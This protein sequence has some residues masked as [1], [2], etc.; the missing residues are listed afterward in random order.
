[1]TFKNYVFLFIDQSKDEPCLAL[2][3]KGP[4][5]PGEDRYDIIRYLNNH[6]EPRENSTKQL[7]DSMLIHMR[8]CL[9]KHDDALY[10]EKYHENVTYN[11]TEECLA[12]SPNEMERLQQDVDGIERIYMTYDEATKQY[13]L[14]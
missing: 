11:T 10:K 5:L 9:T 14:S 8:T 4:L 3:Y 2:A 6:Q 1:M 12:F 13:V 7:L